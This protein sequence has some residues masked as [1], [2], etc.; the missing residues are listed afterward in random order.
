[1]FP[2]TD[3]CGVFYH[4]VTVSCSA[5]MTCTVISDNT[6]LLNLCKSTSYVCLVSEEALK[7]K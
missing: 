1:M 4:S 7:E 6:E 3:L 2:E 5:K